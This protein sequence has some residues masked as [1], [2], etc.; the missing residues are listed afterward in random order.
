MFIT[1]QYYTNISIWVIYRIECTREP[2]ESLEE[3]IFLK[4][5]LPR[6]EYEPLG[7]LLHYTVIMTVGFKAHTD[8][9][10]WQ[11]LT[12]DLILFYN[13]AVFESSVL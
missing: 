11:S 7:I 13:A 6:Y 4:L 3:I 9:I 8:L 5:L 12:I 10:F 2:L 1:V